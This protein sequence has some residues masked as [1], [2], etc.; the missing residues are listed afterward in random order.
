MLYNIITLTG[1]AYFFELC[2]HTSLQVSV[3]IRASFASTSQVRASKTVG[4][5]KI[6]KVGVAFT[7]INFTPSFVIRGKLAQT[8]EGI[9][10]MQPHTQT[11]SIP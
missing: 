6:H 8:L 10:C 9:T 11:Y 1:V 5:V 7:G 4:E 3:L 2:H